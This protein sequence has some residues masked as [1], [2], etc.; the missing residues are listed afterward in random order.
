MLRKINTGRSCN[1]GPKI[2][3]FNPL[4]SSNAVENQKKKYFRG[5][6]QFSI[7]TV[8]KISPLWK[9]EIELFRHF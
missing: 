5:S 1:A 8:K 6:F 4:P 9:P 2:D 3:A 7:V